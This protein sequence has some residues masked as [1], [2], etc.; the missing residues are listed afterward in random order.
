MEILEEKNIKI[1]PCVNMTFNILNS[2]KYLEVNKFKSSDEAKF[3]ISKKD[4]KE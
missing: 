3:P 1:D 2:N 4:E